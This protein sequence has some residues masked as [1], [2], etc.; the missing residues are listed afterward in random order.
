MD[1]DEYPS[2]KR[3][4]ASDVE[5]SSQQEEEPKETAGPTA[6]AVAEEGADAPP[7]AADAVSSE[8]SGRAQ[9]KWTSG[10]GAR[11]G[12]VRDY[13]SEL[14]LRALEQVHLSPRSGGAVAGRAA[15]SRFASPQRSSS[16]TARGRCE[17]LTLGGGGRAASS[18]FASP[19]RSSSPMARGRC[20][21]LTPRE[22]FRTHLMARG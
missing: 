2:L 15:S 1:D 14:Q 16:L 19:Q 10:A 18:R 8:T 9:V 7:E 21:P 6:M 12:C 17:Q 5:A 3:K 11:I 4:Q 13:P 20:E 22:A